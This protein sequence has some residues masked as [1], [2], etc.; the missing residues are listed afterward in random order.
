MDD[1][2]PWFAVRCLVRFE[3]GA[4]TDDGPLYEER[5]TLWRATSFE[6]AVGRA[7]SEV[8]EYAADVEGEYAGLAQAFHLSAGDEVTDGTEVFSLMR[9]SELAPDEYIDRFFETG[10]EREGHVG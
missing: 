3:T 1:D 2:Q 7:E 9:N 5:I 4:G 8:R 10:R 6:E